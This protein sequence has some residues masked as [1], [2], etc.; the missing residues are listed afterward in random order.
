MD[1]LL[2]LRDRTG[3]EVGELMILV[4]TVIRKTYLL[5]AA[6]YPNALREL[7]KD[8]FHVLSAEHRGYP[9]DGPEIYVTV[10][11]HDN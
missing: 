1:G 5:D 11:R 8:G 3:D 10:E 7:L 6:E 2:D 9:A 4:G